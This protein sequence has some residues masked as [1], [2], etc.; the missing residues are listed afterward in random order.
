MGRCSDRLRFHQCCYVFLALYNGALRGCVV[1]RC[2]T[3]T[4][5]D[6]LAGPYMAR[7]SMVMGIIP[8]VFG[9][10]WALDILYKY[11]WLHSGGIW[12]TLDDEF[13]LL[14]ILHQVSVGSA[15]AS[16]LTRH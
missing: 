16:L 9:W 4:V 13:C 5:V 6:D 8:G 14:F 15:F 11:V 2:T 1:R 10:I 7:F 12:V 3:F